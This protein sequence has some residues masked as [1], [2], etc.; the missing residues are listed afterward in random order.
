MDLVIQAKFAACLS[1]TGTKAANIK[2]SVEI[3]VDLNNIK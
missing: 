3:H 2:V 1:S